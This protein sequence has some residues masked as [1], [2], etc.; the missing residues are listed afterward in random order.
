[1]PITGGRGD[2]TRKYG[3]QSV[4]D[5]DH[6]CAEAYPES[7]LMKEENIGHN[8]RY[9]SLTGARADRLNDSSAHQRAVASCVGCPDAGKEEGSCACDEY[10]SLADFQ[11]RWDP[12][13]IA[14]AQK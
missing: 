4:A 7:A 5:G 6:K 13:K 10:W 2:E 3:A 12:E 8:G 1:M 9:E 11:R 14:N